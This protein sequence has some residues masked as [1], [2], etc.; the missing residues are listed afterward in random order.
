MHCVI[1]GTS[2]TPLITYT[3]IIQSIMFTSYLH[4]SITLFL[5]FFWAMQ[6]L[7]KSPWCLQKTPN[8][9]LISFQ[10]LVWLRNTHLRFSKYVMEPKE[11]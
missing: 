11:F 10:V 6:Y 2:N 9:V 8:K 7:S 1:M 5:D 3:K 4:E